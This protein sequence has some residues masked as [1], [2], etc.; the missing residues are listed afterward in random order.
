MTRLPVLSGQEL[1]QALRKVGFEIHHQ[2]GSH[3]ILRR[4]SPPFTRLSVPKHRTLK[5]GLLRC[6]VREAGLT[7]EQS[8]EI[9]GK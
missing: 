1:I 8:M 5:R 4:D 2:K 3:V 9:V 6:L 7:T